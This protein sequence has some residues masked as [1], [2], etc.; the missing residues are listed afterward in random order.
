[1]T[2]A[3]ILLPYIVSES[4]HIKGLALAIAMGTCYTEQGIFRGCLKN[5]DTHAPNLRG[6]WQLDLQNTFEQPAS[7]NLK[8]KQPIWY[9]CK[10]T[11]P[12]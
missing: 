12:T 2:T 7:L 5:T 9:K 8:H 3:V 4:K 1:M 11:V 10:L 6:Q